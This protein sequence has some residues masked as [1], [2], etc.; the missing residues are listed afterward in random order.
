MQDSGITAMTGN[1]IETFA[2]LVRNCLSPETCVPA[3]LDV[4]YLLGNL[5]GWFSEN[6]TAVSS[7][8]PPPSAE[9]R[10]TSLPTPSASMPNSPI[11]GDGFPKRSSSTLSSPESDPPAKLSAELR[12]FPFVTLLL[13]GSPSASPT[14]PSPPSAKKHSNCCKSNSILC[15]L[16]PRRKWKRVI[17]TA[18]IS[19]EEKQRISPS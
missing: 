8:S 3:T 14:A 6:R 13:C 4:A 11:S 7:A 19:H 10:P 9:N 5:D 12:I 17:P 15:S 16:K 18:G 2:G 1:N